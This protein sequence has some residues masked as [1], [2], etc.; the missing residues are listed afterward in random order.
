MNF[1]KYIKDN[2]ENLALYVSGGLDSSLAFYYT[3]KLIQ[4][5]NTNQKIYLIHF[6]DQTYRHLDTVPVL[7]NVINFIQGKFPKVYIHPPHIYPIYSRVKTSEMYVNSYKELA[8]MGHSL[9]RVMMFWHSE[10]AEVCAQHMKISYSEAKQLFNDEAF[11]SPWLHFT[12][13][14]IAKMYKDLNILD[15]TLLTN[16]CIEDQ[17]FGNP[18][19]MCRWCKERY[20]AFGNYDTG[21]L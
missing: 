8:E 3:A 7:H 14:D 5:K 10:D 19:K 16:S 20:N 21:I 9:G 4:D 6:S 11:P 13:S 12:K 1:D 15:L 18:C 17:P 2:G